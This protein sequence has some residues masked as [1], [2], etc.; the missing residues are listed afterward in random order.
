MGEIL[1]LTPPHIFINVNIKVACAPPPHP[2]QRGLLT[3]QK[4]PLDSPKGP[5]K[6]SVN[7]S[8]LD[9]VPI[10]DFSQSTLSSTRQP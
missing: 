1:R 6:P 10:G 5:H 9:N 4:P 2:G 7:S 3:A 8:V